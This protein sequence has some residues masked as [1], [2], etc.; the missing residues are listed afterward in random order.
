MWG[1]QSCREGTASQEG[2]ALEQV[3]PRRC[4]SSLIWLSSSR[5]VTPCEGPQLRQG[6]HCSIMSRNVPA[7]RAE[8]NFWV[9]IPSS[10]VAVKCGSATCQQGSRIYLHCANTWCTIHV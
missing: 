3:A 7:M 1:Q 4:Q 5:N 8:V 2:A 10:S 6:F 9:V